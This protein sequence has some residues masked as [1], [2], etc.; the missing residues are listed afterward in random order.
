MVGAS[1][2]SAVHEAIG[3]G[4]KLTKFLDAYNKQLAAAVNDGTY[5]KLYRKYFPRVDYPQS[6]LKY[7]PSLKTQLQGP[8]R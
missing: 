2:E 6:M 5:L 3:V 4:K 1:V 7:W 8:L